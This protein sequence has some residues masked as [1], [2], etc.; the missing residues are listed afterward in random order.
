[1]NRVAILSSPEYAKCREK[2]AEG[3]DLLNF[4]DD[5]R[6]KKGTAEA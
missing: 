2:I 1:M 6:E 3:F 5:V 4:D